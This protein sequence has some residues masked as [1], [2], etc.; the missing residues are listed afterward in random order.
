MPSK[1]VR[2]LAERWG[3]KQNLT[4]SHRRA[5]KQEA[6]LAALVRGSRV[7]GSGAGDVKGDVRR[8]GLLRIEAKTTRHASFSVTLEMLRKIE[9]AATQSGEMPAIVVEFNDGK[10]KPLGSVAI[11]PLYALQE[12]VD[13]TG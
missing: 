3:A 8:K 5:P 11:L 9:Q 4:P 1:T 6:S 10:G 12:L 2:S 13:V 7:P